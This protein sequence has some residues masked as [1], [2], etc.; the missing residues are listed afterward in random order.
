MPEGALVI[1][2]LDYIYVV[3]EPENA[4][5]IFHMVKDVLPLVCHIDVSLGKLAARS[6][7]AAACPDGL[8]DISTTASKSDAHEDG[9]GVKV[10]G[11]PLGTTE[12]V[13]NVGL[14][15]LQ[16]KAKLLQLL[17]ELPSLQAASLLLF[18]P[19]KGSTTCGEL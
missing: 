7:V 16:E 17:L 6:T 9:R 14:D 2:Y 13:N 8:A 12:F 15:L 4:A 19:Y 5:L 18:A 3:C 10:L 11:S 1:A